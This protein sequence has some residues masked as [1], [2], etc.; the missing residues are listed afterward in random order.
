[1]EALQKTDAIIPI[2]LWNQGLFFEFHEWIEHLWL[3]ESGDRKKA[4]RALIL[5][6]VVY[7]QLAYSRIVP[8]KKL[9]KKAILIFKQQAD[10]LPEWADNAL[11]IKKLTKLNLGPPILEIINHTNEWKLR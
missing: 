8:A 7:E 6:A 9:A 1:M 11:F 3:K 2:L 4:L 5:A 10:Q